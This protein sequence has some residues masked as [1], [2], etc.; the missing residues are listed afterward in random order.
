MGIVSWGELEKVVVTGGP[1]HFLT[2]CCLRAGG[3]EKV[4][5]LMGVLMW[6]PDDQVSPD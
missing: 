5:V 1:N 2:G 6:W 4:W 3:K